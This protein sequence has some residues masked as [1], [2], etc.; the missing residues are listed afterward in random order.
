MRNEQNK[1]C[2]SWHSVVTLGTRQP[3]REECLSAFCLKSAI[4]AYF[5]FT[6]EVA[7]FLLRVEKGIGEAVHLFFPEIFIERL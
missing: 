6:Q 2:R 5:R 7:K 3:P 4:F 1:A